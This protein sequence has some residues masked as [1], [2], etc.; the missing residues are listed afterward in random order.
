LAVFQDEASQVSTSEVS[1]VD[2]EVVRF[3][4]ETASMVWS[5]G[6]KVGGWTTNGN[7]LHWD[8]SSVAFRVRFG[9]ENGERRAFFTETE[10]GTICDL[11]IYAPDQMSIYAS[12]ERPPE[13]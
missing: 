13:E 2:R 11:D 9:T 7:D 3:D 8:R 5:D 6:T 4:E 10:A 12:S 1:D